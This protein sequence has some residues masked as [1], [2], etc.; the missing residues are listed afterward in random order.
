MP[1]GLIIE[2]GQV[3]NVPGCPAKD[4]GGGCCHNCAGGWPGTP[5]T[6]GMTRGVASGRLDPEKLGC[7]PLQEMAERAYR[8]VDDQRNAL[9]TDTIFQR[10]GPAS[11]PLAEPGPI[12]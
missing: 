1:S 4:G 7:G 3:I 12:G 9:G 2:Q 8:M 10:E 5:G 6:E 11:A